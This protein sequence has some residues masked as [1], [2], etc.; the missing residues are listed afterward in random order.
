MVAQSLDERQSLDPDS[1][2]SEAL[3]PLVEA[4]LKH[5][6]REEPQFWAQ[7]I[8]PILGSAI[9][10]AVA[11]ALRDM[12]QTIN[13]LLESSLSLRSWRWRVEAWRTGKPFAEVVLLHTLV[14]R[15]EQVLLVDRNSGLLLAAASAPGI[16][17]ENSDLISAMLT[18]IQEFVHDSFR[19]AQG[20]SIRQIQTGEFSLWVE[21]GPS[22]ALAAAVRGNAPIEFHQVLREAVDLIHEDLGTELRDFQGDSTAIE[23]R[24]RAIL[25][26]CLQSRFQKPRPRSYWRVW[27][28]AATVA[29]ALLVWGGLKM[30]DA[31]RWN[32][33][34]EDLLATPGITVTGS[35]REHGKRILQGLRDPFAARAE[36]ILARNG[37]SQRDVALHLEPIISLEPTLLTRRIRAAI[38]APDSVTV[39][40]DR[41]ALTLGG[42]A[43]HEWI[44][45]ALSAA[46]KVALI[47]IGEVRMEGIEDRDLEA[48]RSEIEALKILFPLGS[49][50]I[51]PD[52]ARLI[53]GVIPKL[54]QWIDGTNEI[55]RVPK[56]MVVGHADRTGAEA[57]NAA[58]SNQRAHRVTE[59]LLAAGIPSQP[60]TALA[61]GP[62]ES[63]QGNAEAVPPDPAMRRNVVFRLSSKPCA[64]GTERH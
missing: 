45:S 2:F 21:P 53:H 20:D 54:R 28:C 42:A 7:T 5:S 60:L 15:V 16:S 49:S 34:L 1:R 26:G 41:G 4:A 55:R 62:D 31:R 6:V 30:R 13:Q 32:R 24:G 29:S 56:V 40:L 50:A 9:R 12:V 48:L 22:A 10:A 46:Q 17:T 36:N 14:Y 44:V 11:S 35:T 8:S 61:A 3:R 19:L 23:Q 25:E 47:G 58:L 18:A 52:Q 57:A 63:S 43:S 33:A 59:L 64:T 39:S 38:D 27:A 51:A 37:I